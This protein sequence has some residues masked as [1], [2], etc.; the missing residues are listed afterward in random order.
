MKEVPGLARVGIKVVLGTEG[1]RGG[2]VDDRE[3]NDTPMIVT[4]LLLAHT[5]TEWQLAGFI[6]SF[7]SI[8]FYLH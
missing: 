4:G 8:C 7:L 2:V 3:L 6:I 1:G 5:E